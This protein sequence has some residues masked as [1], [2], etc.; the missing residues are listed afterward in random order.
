MPGWHVITW[1]IVFAAPVNPAV[2]AVAVAHEPIHL[3]ARVVVGMAYLAGVSQ[4]G[5][6]VAWYRGM[7]VIGVAR[8]SQLQLAQLLLTLVWAVLMLGEHLSAAVPLTAG[9][10][11]GCIVVTQRARV[12]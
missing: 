11:L 6:F 10:V 3:T 9:I 12:P 2:C 4:F 1:A 7:G 5:G 8:A